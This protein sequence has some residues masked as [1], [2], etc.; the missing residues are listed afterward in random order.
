HPRYAYR[1]A[2]QHVA[3]RYFTPGEGRRFSDAIALLR[4]NH[5]HLHLTDDQ[6]WRLQIESW[7]E[8]PRIGGSTGSD[9]SRGGCYTQDEFREIVAYAAARHITVVP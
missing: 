5:H 2:V 8:L 9:G 6:G 3:P 7:P 1:G 4:A